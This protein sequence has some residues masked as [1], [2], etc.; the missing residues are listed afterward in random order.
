[1]RIGRKTKIILLTILLL[2]IFVL[3]A[4]V[5]SNTQK[6]CLSSDCKKTGNEPNIL[7]LNDP[8]LFYAAKWWA[9]LC[10]NEKDEPGG[11]Y[12]ESY[13]YN[14]GK[15]EE[16]IGFVKYDGSPVAM[17]QPPIQKQLDAAELKRIKE[18][19]ENSGLMTK[20]CPAQE[21]SDAGWDYQV[22]L[23][24]KKISLHNPPLECRNVFDGISQLI[25]SFASK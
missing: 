17:T 9:G 13:L 19:I 20:N 23:N 15:F 4:F 25:N 21:I 14:D 16:I 5:I 3:F 2:V 18:I 7:K 11:C 12:S 8:N 1:M 6:E 22:T 10:S 24:G